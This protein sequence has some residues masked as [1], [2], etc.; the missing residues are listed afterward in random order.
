MK[1]GDLDPTYPAHSV[2]ELGQECGVCHRG[3]VMSIPE[4]LRTAILEEIMSCYKAMDDINPM[5][6]ID[7]TEGMMPTVGENDAKRITVLVSI[8]FGKIN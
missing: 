7:E 4:Q 6:W 5:Q 2:D 8:N 3:D 1:K